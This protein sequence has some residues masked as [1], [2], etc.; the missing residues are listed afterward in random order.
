MSFIL[1]R[2]LKYVIFG[3]YFVLISVLNLVLISFVRLLYKIVCLL[4]R[5][6]FVFFLNVVRIILVFD[7]LIFF[8]YVNVILRVFF[9]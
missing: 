1:C 2:Y 6:V 4:K 9:V 7:V 3:W 8:V 5:F